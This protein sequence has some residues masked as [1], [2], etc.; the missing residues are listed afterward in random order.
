[1]S[2][3]VVNNMSRVI[4]KRKQELIHSDVYLGEEHDD[5]LMHW[6][7]IKREKVNGKWRY[8]YTDTGVK[9]IQKKF[10]EADDDLISTQERARAYDKFIQTYQSQLDKKNGGDTNKTDADKNLQQWKKEQK[11]IHD[12][13]PEKY[14]KA[15]HLRKQYTNALDKYK[16]SFGHDVADFLNKSSDNIEKGKK[17]IKNLFK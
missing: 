7:Y 10:F 13:I 5:G 9:D 4:V 15:K 16:N 1:M 12:T 2:L 3:V 6:K 14:Q 17:W 8:Y 11:A